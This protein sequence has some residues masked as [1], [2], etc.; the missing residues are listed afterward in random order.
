MLDWAAEHY[1]A[2]LNVTRGVVAVTQPAA[3]L[4]ALRLAV[5][6]HDDFAL[7]AL[8]ALTATCGSVG[9]ALAVSGG[10]LSASEA[11]EASLLDESYQAEQWGADPAAIQRRAGIHAEIASAARFLACR[12]Q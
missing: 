9:L 5:E 7:S 12:V 10:R 1:G 6:A 11:A 3:A 8:H 2:S 4:S